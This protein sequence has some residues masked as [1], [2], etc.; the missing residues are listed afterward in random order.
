MNYAAML[1]ANK[2]QKVN[3]SADEKNQLLTRGAVSNIPLMEGDV[4]Y[5]PESITP[6]FRNI[7]G[8][9]VVLVE[10]AKLP[11]ADAEF[12]PDTCEGVQL[13]AIAFGRCVT[14]PQTKVTVTPKTVAEESGASYDSA[15]LLF[16]SIQSLTV[17][18]VIRYVA[19][20][21]LSIL[22]T[23]AVELVNP[24][25]S[26]RLNAQGQPI[27]QTVYAFVEV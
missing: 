12:N 6:Q 7:A 3:L 14:N 9:N 22:A 15:K 18:D 11:T 5:F 23:Q 24:D 17:G 26:K 16:N 19:G 27:F 20:K 4:I 25:G 8:T 2:A 21:K 1:V 13:G 10:G